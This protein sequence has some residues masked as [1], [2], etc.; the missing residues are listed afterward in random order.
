MENESLQYELTHLVN[1]CA[2]PYR[3]SWRNY[4][5]AKAQILARSNPETYS[6]LPALL[7]K[8]LSQ[9]P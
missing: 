6:E 8:A 3:E 7:T 4:V 1:L 9:S 5:W 2:P